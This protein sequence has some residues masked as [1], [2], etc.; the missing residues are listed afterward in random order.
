VRG[1]TRGTR[2]SARAIAISFAVAVGAL[3][4]PSASAD[5]H[6][7][8]PANEQAG[9]QQDDAS[10]VAAQPQTP[11]APQVFDIDE[12]RVEGADTLEQS[13]V[14][15]AVYPYLGPQRT[16]ADIEKARAALEKRYHDKGFQTVGVAVR[17]QD[18]EGRYVAFSVTE[19]RVGHVRVT[20]SKYHDLDTIKDR[21]RSLKP[22]VLPDFD[23][24]TKDI[25]ALNQWPD[26]RVTP[27]L[28]AGVTPGTVDVDLNVEDKLPLH[29]NVEL[30][31][32]QSANTTD[33]R[34]NGT[35]HYDNLWQR[36]HSLSFTYQTAPKR[37][38]DMEAFSASYL[39][40]IPNIEWLSILSYGVI[41]RSDVALLGDINVVGPGETFGMRGVI[42]LPSKENFYHTL[43][44]GLDYKNF[45]QTLSLG[46]DSFDSPIT[47]FPV[48]AA[49]SAT[50]QLEKSL[51]QV[52]A[53]VTHGLRGFGS[54][55]WAE[56]DTKRYM[57]T[58]NFFT[59][60]A[61]L[62]E[63][64]ELPEGFQLFGRIGGQLGDQPLVSSEQYSIGG[65]QTVRGYLE[66]TALGDSGGSATLEIR[67][68][69]IGALLQTE[70]EKSGEAPKDRKIFNDWRL[71]AF[72]DGGFT[73]I[74]EPLVEQES[75]SK[76]W[77]YGAGTTFKV[78]DALS[79]MVAVAVPEATDSS[80]KEGEPRVLFRIWGDL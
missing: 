18:I 11:T 40:R 10:A 68:P 25:I 8:S 50:W 72:V 45:G 28:R 61:E 47:Y 13:E 55:S 80:V 5:P 71:F 46:A 41:S 36:G 53:T 37:R 73:M 20:N 21:A 63:T 2:K 62:S 51:T 7:P 16:S 66:S 43:S 32:R 48:V 49:Y 27:A 75:R 17:H 26:R 57:A 58:P 76:L 19:M 69:N 12:Y 42:T 78:L 38:D 33:L 56:W 77:S 74:H 39:A 4:S 52:N 24:A 15:E 67:S 44:I 34:L 9:S 6:Q 23:D 14:E 29:A 31:N 79:G 35:I 1:S 64:Y 22:G 60:N 54:D 70:L 3:A 30:N 65:L 59:F